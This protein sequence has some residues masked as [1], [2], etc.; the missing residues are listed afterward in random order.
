[1]VQVTSD[2]INLSIDSTSGG[3]GDVWMRLVSFYV[4]ADLMKN[5]KIQI[6]VP[7]VLQKLA[8]YTFGD[9]LTIVQGKIQSDYYYSNLGMKN[10]IQDIFLGKKYLSPYHRSVIRDRKKRNLKDY[11]NILGFNIADWL[12]FVQVPSWKWISS[13]QGYLDIVTLKKLRVISYDRY[14]E[15]LA[16]D[17]PQIM[18]KLK[19]KIPTSP[20]LAIPAD[21]NEHVIIFPTGTS[22]QFI[23]LWWARKNMPDAYYAFFFKDK[24]AEMFKDHGLKTVFFYQEPGDIITLSHHAKWTISTDSFPSHLLQYATNKCTIAITEVLKS[25]IISPAFTGI[26]IDARVNCHPCLHL[27]RKRHPKCMAG[28]EEC[29]NWKNNTYTRELLEFKNPAA[30]ENISL[31]SHI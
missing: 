23:P 26:V 9:R 31:Y 30:V 16:A 19:G 2:K 10:L 6:V 29:L 17:Y 24:E 15:Q 28:Y 27:E 4:I 22:R 18:T 20:E 7:P 3:N 11:L 25:R 8:E 14:K 1:M 5:L 12:G 21:L 13:Y